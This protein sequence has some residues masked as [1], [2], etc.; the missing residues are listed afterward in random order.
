MD[1]EHDFY[2]DINRLFE[3]MTR[4]MA[5]IMKDRLDKGE[6]DGDVFKHGFRVDI[7]PNGPKI[8]PMNEEELEEFEHMAHENKMTPFKPHFKDQNEKWKKP[9]TDIYETESG[10]KVICDLQGIETND[11]TLESKQDK[12]LLIT[13]Q[14]EE[15]KYRKIL[16]FELPIDMQKIDYVVRNGVLEL[17]LYIL[18]EEN[19]ENF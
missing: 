18:T 8:H 10:Y 6:I 15:F 1:D 7:G 2:K 12:K 14:N 3:K 19:I 5:R 11:L 4:E 9:L 13:A 16:S 17:N